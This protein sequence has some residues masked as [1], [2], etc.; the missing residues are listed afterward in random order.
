MRVRC[1]LK[2]ISKHLWRETITDGGPSK[3]LFYGNGFL[4]GFLEKLSRH[5]HIIIALR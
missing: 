4:S 1:V 2:V 3:N 5:Q